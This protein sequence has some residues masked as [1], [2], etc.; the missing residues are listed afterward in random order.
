MTVR[1]ELE[2]FLRRPSMDGGGGLPLS[3]SP[4]SRSDDA[5]GLPVGDVKAFVGSIRMGT[6]G[7]L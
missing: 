5:T 2:E 3:L 6:A 4:R 1:R 7:G